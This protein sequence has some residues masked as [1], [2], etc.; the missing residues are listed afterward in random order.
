MFKE[1]QNVVSRPMVYY[2]SLCHQN[3]VVEEI[4]DL[5]SWLKK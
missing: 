2:L 1:L 3:N 4:K 5:R